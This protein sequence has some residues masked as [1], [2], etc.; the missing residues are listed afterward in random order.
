MQDQETTD[1]FEIKRY[2]IP[3]VI[4][5]VGT[6]L[7]IISFIYASYI[8]KEDWYSVQKYIPGV[9]G[10]GLVATI[11]MSIAL[12]FFY[13]NAPMIGAY[14]PIIMSSIAL[15]VASVALLASCMNKS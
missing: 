11:L 3:I 10:S 15:S 7:Y 13:Y 9:A 14:A 12:L 2:Y 4:T 5:I 1:L 8:N 6:I